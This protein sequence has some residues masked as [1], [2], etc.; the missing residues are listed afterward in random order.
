MANEARLNELLDL[1]EQARAEGDTDTERKA[2]AAYKAE[3]NP[4]TLAQRNPAEFDSASPQW[5][6][7]YG[8]TAGMSG[9]EKFLAGAGKAFVD[10]GRGVG[11]LFGGVSRQDVAQSRAL[12]APLMQSGAAKAGNIVGNVAATIPAIA[13]PGANTVVGAGAVGA[14][15]GL[16]QPSTSTRETL[17]NVGVGGAVGAGSQYLGGKVA[18]WATNK[19]GQRAAKSASDAELNAVRDATLKEAQAA[20]YVVPP[21]TTN[22]TVTNR[23]IEGVSGKAATQQA[24]AL[25]NQQIT[26]RLVRQEL[27]LGETVPLTKGT[28][29]ALRSKAGA[30]YKAISGAGEIATDGQYVDDLA[31]I[32]QSMDD[33]SK[34]FPDLNLNNNEEISKLIDGMLQDK[35][36]AKSA[37]ELT[38]QLRKSAS[39]NLGGMN[40]ADPAKRALGYAQRDAAAAVEDQLIR[41]LDATGKGGL[42]KAL[43]ESR[44]LIAKTYSVE[45]ALNEGTGNVVATNLSAQLKKGKPLS[46][47]LEL[48]AKFGKAFGKA[49]KEVT[50]SPGVSALDAMFGV[51]GGATLNPAFLALPVARVATRGAITN[52]AINRLMSTPSYSPGTIG[53]GV[54]KTGRT[55]GTYGAIPAASFAVQGGQ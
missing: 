6:A 55:L 32:A 46:G 24:A 11:Q 53:Q 42:G 28:L 5:Q 29:N 19:L 41:H 49:A 38:K 9:G 50:D 8:P 17:M 48:V 20:G 16:L 15:L 52:Q 23:V 25:K 1:V 43:D 37:I 51:A 35:F 39:G 30:V 54:L 7:K 44:K 31:A 33:V 34:D 27:G 40:A 4:Q 14:G 36:S 21:S 45:A 10:L 22:P 47:N 18:Q 3:S 2:I 12:D 13:I 26:N